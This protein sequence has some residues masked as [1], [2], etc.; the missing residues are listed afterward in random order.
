MNEVQIIDTD[1]R[2]H[3]TQQWVEFDVFHAFEKTAISRPDFEV[4]VTAM[5]RDDNMILV[6]LTFCNVGK[7]IFMRRLIN[8]IIFAMREN[9]K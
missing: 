4:N 2:K 7:T 8:F 1:C 6:K 3:I 5:Q 9:Y